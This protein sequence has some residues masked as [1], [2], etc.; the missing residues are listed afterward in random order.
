MY[1]VFL[2]LNE[3]ATV[4]LLNPSFANEQPV[5]LSTCTRNLHRVKGEIAMRAQGNLIGQLTRL[6]CTLGLLVA[7]TSALNQALAEPTKAHLHQQS[8]FDSTSVTAE[9]LLSNLMQHDQ[10]RARLLQ[11]YSV[12]RTYLVKSGGGKLRSEAHVLLNYEAPDRKEFKVVSE[13]GPSVIRNLVNTLLKSEV[14]AASE[15]SNLNSSITAANYTFALWGKEEIDGLP[16]FVVQAIPKRQDICLFEGKV[17]ID[18]REF[19]IVKITGE[20]AKNPSFWIKKAAFVRQY[21]RIGGCWLPLKDEI[22]AEIRIFGGNTLTIYHNNYRVRLR[23]DGTLKM[24][25]AS[26]DLTRRLWLKDLAIN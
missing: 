20:P 9:V 7:E 23:D 16:C 26:L 19:A 10:L 3:F 22:T 24:T 12:D 15:R 13:D 8:L 17:W 5:W 11:Q 1:S 25:A 18:A 2:L 21:Q 14:E 4:S 6:T